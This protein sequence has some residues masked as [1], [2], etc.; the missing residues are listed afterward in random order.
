MLQLLKHFTTLSMT[1][2]LSL[3]FPLLFVWGCEARNA[4]SI[5]SSRLEINTFFGTT[6]LSERSRP[7]SRFKPDSLFSQIPPTIKWD[8]VVSLTNSVQVPSCPSLPKKWG[9]AL[10][11][12]PYNE[13]ER[14]TFHLLDR[15]LIK[16]ALTNRTTYRSKKTYLEKYSRPISSCPDPLTSGGKLDQVL[17]NGLN[18]SADNTSVSAFLKFADRKVNAFPHF[19]SSSTKADADTG[20]DTGSNSEK[21]QISCI[22]GISPETDQS[23]EARVAL[24]TP[25]VELPPLLK[26]E[27]DE[28]WAEALQ[29]K[30]KSQEKSPEEDR[31]MTMPKT[32]A[33]NVRSPQRLAKSKTVKFKLETQLKQAELALIESQ[34]QHDLC[35]MPLCFLLL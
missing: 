7:Y 8:R 11:I 1:R 24:P 4:T 26:N 29:L 31:K 14:G 3:L 19:L 32:T 17:S 18:A 10:L 28:A 34:S 9:D 20:L 5:Q 12:A 2:T 25:E 16:T 21:Q 6:S 15:R 30:Q 33:K 23:T 22:S 35:K 27:K 13:S